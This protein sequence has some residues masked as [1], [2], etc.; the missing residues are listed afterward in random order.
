M[1][2]YIKERPIQI[3]DIVGQPNVVK[4]VQKQSI[5]DSFSHAYLLCG[6]FGGGKTSTA[7]IIAKLMTCPNKKDDKVCGTCKICKSINSGCCV[8]VYEIDAASKRGIDDAR[9]IRD[10]ANYAPQDLKKKIY[11]IDECHMLTNEAWNALLKTIEEPPPFIAFI[12]CTTEHRKVPNTI[13]SRCQRFY[14]N[15]LSINNIQDKLITIAEKYNIQLD[16]Q[17]ANGIAKISKGSMRDAINYLEQMAV[18]HDNKISKDN[19]ANY[20]GMPDGRLSYQIVQYIIDQNVSQLMATIDEVL[21][22]GVD[23]K[24]MVCE[25]T[26]VFRNIFILKTC[27]EKSHLLHV[28]DDEKT[29][30]SGFAEKLKLS[31]LTKIANSFS[32][33]EKDIELNINERWIL[34]AALVNCLMIA[35]QN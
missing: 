27:G 5:G 35:K 25:V 13:M 32:R 8:D 7:R 31:S 11:I 24:I 21:S 20:F 6:Q 12:F 4:A 18:V 30:L 16:V 33:L 3:A 23:P 34:E 2:L 1:S 9:K 28:L 19:F 22:T 29:T 10:T 17:V 14:F 15:A 26:D